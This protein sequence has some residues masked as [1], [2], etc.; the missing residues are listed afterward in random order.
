V[1]GSAML[2]LPESPR[3]LAS[4]NRSERAERA[5]QR[6]EA[7]SPLML[8]RRAHA[9]AREQEDVAA[10]AN[11]V[12]DRDETKPRM[13]GYWGRLSVIVVLMFLQA[14]GQTGFA[15]LLTKALLMK[16]MAMQEALAKSSLIFLMMPLGA[17]ACAFV[18]DRMG[19]R[20]LFVGIALILATS[21]M[22]FGL[23]Q[24]PTL[25]LATR[26]VYSFF[27]AAFTSAGQ[28]YCA[29]M[30]PTAIR[31]TAVGVGYVGVRA[32]SACVPIVMLP[33]LLDRGPL[34]GV[35]GDRGL[36]ARRRGD[37]ARVRATD[38]APHPPEVRFTSKCRAVQID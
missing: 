17:I 38:H 6:F 5:V 23:A 35:L 27:M 37:G 7:S 33:L 10:P 8:G 20:T 29:E 1:L 31:G 28:I 2:V 11:A 9:R 30:F 19:R 18:T 21:A 12:P 4:R 16:G 3:W 36:A 24:D 26:M 32:G 14:S 13:T 25:L 34:G 15:L 22:V